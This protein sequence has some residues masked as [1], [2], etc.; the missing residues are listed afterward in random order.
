MSLRTILRNILSTWVGYAVSLII[1]LL[2]SPF[3]VHHL[4]NTGYGV[5]TLVVSLTG[6]FGTLDLGLRQSVGRFVARYM[7]LNDEENVN[8]TISNAFTLLGVAGMLSLLAAVIV[9][10]GLGIFHIEPNYRADAKIALLISGLNICLA[11]PMSVFSAVLF[12][13]E[14]FD[15]VTG[16]SILG[17]LTRSAMIVVFLSRGY[18]V[19]ALALIMLCASSAEYVLSAIMARKLYPRLRPRRCHVETAKCKELFNFGIYR[20]I[21]I[22]ANQLIFYADTI[23]IGIFLSAGAIT[24]YAVAGSLINYGR[25][26]VALAADT[27]S[28]ASSALDAKNDTKGL[29]DLLILGTGIAL[30]VGLPICVG[31]LFLGKQF[32]TLWMGPA[33]AI[34]AAYLIVLTIAQFTSMPQYTSAVVLVSMA[35]HKTLA[36]VTVGEGITNLILSIILVRKFGLVGVAWG[37]VIPH[38]ISTAVLIPSFTLGALKMKWSDYLVRGLVRPVLAAIPAAGVC[39]ALSV[40]VIAPSWFVFGAEVLAV[41]GTSALMSYCVCLSSQQRRFIIERLRRT[42]QRA[43]VTEVVGG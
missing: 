36:Y 16:I 11:L 28:P 18:G 9:T 8:R 40:L 3:V 35:K 2:L 39:Y 23:V 41:G 14:R 24:Y 27:L 37:T 19:I 33:Y 10:F 32:I 17:A 29:Q 42:S 6:Y 1:G 4:G 38:I 15:V 20:F 30:T 13:L 31:F 22:V 21:W 26:I 43:P 12:S 25:N 34:S 7:A 5:W